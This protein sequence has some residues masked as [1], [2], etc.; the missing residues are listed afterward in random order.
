[1]L[2]IGC[3]SIQKGMLY[4]RDRC[5]ACFLRLQDPVVKALANNIIQCWKQKTSTSSGTTAQ[6]PAYKPTPSNYPYNFMSNN[7]MYTQQPSMDN[8]YQQMHQY[9]MYLQMYQNYPQNN[10]PYPYYPMYQ[11]K[12]NE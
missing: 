10:N 8:Y 2:L 9:Y 11:N 1:M 5:E 7:N 12:K 4:V 6:P 3:L